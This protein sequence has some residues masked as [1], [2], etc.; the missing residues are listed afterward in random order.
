MQWYTLGPIIFLL[1]INDLF[2]ITDQLKFILFVD[3]KNVLISGKHMRMTTKVLNDELTKQRP[4]KWLKIENLL[5]N[6][7]KTNYMAFSNNV[8]KRHYNNYIDNICINWISAC[9]L[10]GVLADE[11]ILWKTS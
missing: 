3:D 11:N 1:Y 2:N 10:T 7:G 6:V 9:R 8:E 4:S 5:L